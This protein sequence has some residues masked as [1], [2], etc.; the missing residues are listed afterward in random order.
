MSTAEKAQKSHLVSQIVWI[1]GIYA[2]LLITM[3]VLA[4]VHG[5]TNSALTLIQV[6]GTRS[7]LMGAV[8]LNV[9][10]LLGFL[11]FLFIFLYDASDDRADGVIAQVGAFISIALLFA[12]D[13]PYAVFPLLVALYLFWGYLAHDVVGRFRTRKQE[14]AVDR[15]EALSRAADLAM[16]LMDAG[17]D[18]AQD[19]FDEVQR[20]VDAE[21]RQMKVQ[22]ADMTRRRSI[23]LTAYL[24]M[25]L[26]LFVASV[27]PAVMR[28]RPWL[29]EEKL[30]LGPAGKATLAKDPAVKSK[31]PP[32]TDD[33]V[34]GY[35][36]ETSPVVTKILLD[37]PRRVVIIAT[38]DLKSREL[39]KSGTVQ[40]K[41][42]LLA[43][44]FGHRAN[45]KNGC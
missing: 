17:V 23:T 27:Y 39:C 13:A 40:S 9:R 12:V 6:G 38:T 16:K 36:L 45:D 44:G 18:G 28:D 21:S 10:A 2:A 14:P 11:A 35:V 20:L 29:S 3:N 26:Y 4:I 43:W 41:Y 25:C 31:L 42:S 7:I 5:D 33:P 37:D 15:T 1:T 8:I 34:A 32:N 30:T 19:V 22:M 24:L